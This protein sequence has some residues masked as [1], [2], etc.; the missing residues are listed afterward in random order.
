MS[1]DDDRTV[2][3][4]GEGASEPRPPEEIRRDIEE[5]REELGDTVEAL[6]AKTDVKA[7]AQQAAQDA[8]QQAKAK[9]EEAKSKVTSAK[10]DLVGKAQEASPEGAQ[11]AA[12]EASRKARENP[13]PVAVAGAAVVGF[14]LGR[15]S[16]R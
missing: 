5:T 4:D 10:D 8:K 9:V 11:N 3:S 12:V 15:L 2:V 16:K 1:A 14:L 6:A 13:L 7:Q